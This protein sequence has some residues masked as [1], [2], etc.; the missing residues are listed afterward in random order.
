M[1]TEFPQTMTPLR[2]ECATFANLKDYFDICLKALVESVNRIAVL[3]P[4]WQNVTEEEQANG[5]V[6]REMAHL[7]VDF[8]SEMVLLLAWLSVYFLQKIGHFDLIFE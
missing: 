5:S 3:N 8:L 6:D 7:E 1:S 4:E 2:A